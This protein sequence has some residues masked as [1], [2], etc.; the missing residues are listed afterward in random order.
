MDRI[1]DLLGDVAIATGGN[2]C[3]T[4]IRKEI[5]KVHTYSSYLRGFPVDVT[6]TWSLTFEGKSQG[7]SCCDG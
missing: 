2:T 3:N 5:H 1:P 4:G 6:N 7:L